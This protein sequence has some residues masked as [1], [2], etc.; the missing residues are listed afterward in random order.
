MT[1]NRVH[2]PEALRLICQ[3]LGAISQQLP[4]TDSVVLLSASEV[5]ELRSKT[6]CNASCRMKKIYG[7]KVE[8]IS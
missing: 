7:W 4:A 8:K 6:L 3:V 5:A 1:G 2:H